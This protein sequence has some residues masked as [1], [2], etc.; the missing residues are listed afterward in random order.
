MNNSTSNESI[1]TPAVAPV[2]HRVPT[3]CQSVNIR[4][5]YSIVCYCVRPQTTQMVQTI[6]ARDFPPSH[7][8]KI[9]NDILENTKK[10]Q[11]SSQ[12]SYVNSSIYSH[13][14]LLRNFF[15]S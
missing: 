9:L 5:L 4:L 8:D 12:E 14:I 11:S 1:T 13:P 3:N 2:N 7:D 6:A 10:L 15:L